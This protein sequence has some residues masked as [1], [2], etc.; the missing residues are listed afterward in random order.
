MLSGKAGLVPSVP[1]TPELTES[2]DGLTASDWVF[3]GVI[4]V[5]AFL[6]ALVVRQI[7]ERVVRGGDGTAAVAA[8]FVGRTVGFLVVV[9]GFIYALSVLH[10]RLAPLLGAL[11]I[12]GLALAFAAQSILANVFASVLLQVRHPFRRGDQIQ[13]G[14]HE[15][16]VEEVNFRTVVLRT[17][18]GERVSIPCAQVLDNPIVNRTHRGTRRTTLQVGVSYDTDLEHAQPIL[19]G[20]TARIEGVLE[21]PAPEAWVEGFGESSIDFAVRF[22]HA[23]QQAVMWRVRSAV[24][25]ETKRA[26][27]EAG[28]TIPFPQRDVHFPGAP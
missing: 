2:L 24:A 19:L 16:T 25:V 12:G 18:D 20:A 21:S 28:I 8:R 27:D 5:V 6:L 1:D 15:G 13:S 26:L 11:G 22:W 3:A 14:D 9:I 23:P 10:V 4:V 7:T 17:F